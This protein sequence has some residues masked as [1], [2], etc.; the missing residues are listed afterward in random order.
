M[1]F[2]NAVYIASRSVF[3]FFGI[4][5]YYHYMEEHKCTGFKRIDK[6]NIRM[7]ECTCCGQR[8]MHPSPAVNGGLYHWRKTYIEEDEVIVLTTIE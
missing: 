4:H 1:G 2:L 8:W 7:R 3:C 6:L 5:S